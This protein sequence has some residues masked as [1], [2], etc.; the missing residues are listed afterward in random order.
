MDSTTPAKKLTFVNLM[1]SVREAEF[2]S[3]IDCKF[4]YTSKKLALSLIDNGLAISSNC[5]FKIVAEI[6]YLPKS[7]KVR[8]DILTELL[9]YTEQKFQHPLKELMFEIARRKIGGYQINVDEVI[10]KM[11]YVA[12]YTDQFEALNI[13]YFASVIH[14]ESID[15]KYEEVIMRWKHSSTLLAP[16]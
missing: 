3:N 12:N 6:M 15:L 4:P 10:N 5:A 11:D 16:R 14:E 2:I 7:I 9:T 1:N 8:S 13:L